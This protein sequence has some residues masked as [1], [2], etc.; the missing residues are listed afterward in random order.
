VATSQEIEGEAWVSVAVDFGT[1][2]W[3]GGH[4]TLQ[5]GSNSACNFSDQT[6][7]YEG[8]LTPEIISSMA[9]LNPVG[10]LEYQ[11]RYTA[12]IAGK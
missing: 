5:S 6:G 4:Y 8:I 2:G 9:R 7:S 12:S 10:T 11:T 1:Q 3:K